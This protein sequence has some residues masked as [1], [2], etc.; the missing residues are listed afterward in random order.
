MNILKGIVTELRE[1]RLWPV[2]VALLIGLVAVPVVLSKS[3]S[4]SA[5]TQAPAAGGSGSTGHTVSVKLAGGPGDAGLHG[6]A[7]DPFAQQHGA[8]ATTPVGGV[9]A[10]SG[11]S[12]SLAS[13]GTSVSVGA[14]S[15][16]STGSGSSPRGGSSV[17][18][19]NAGGGS[20]SSVTSAGG[21]YSAPAASGQ[22]ATPVHTTKPAPAG[23][24][25]TQSY[26]VAIQVS[27]SSGG[28]NLLD[29]VERL[30]PIPSGSQPLLVELGVAQGGRRVLFAVQPGTIVTGPGSCTPGPIDCEILSLSPDQT[31]T[32]STQL[33]GGTT[34]AQFA[35]T[36]ISAADHPSVAAANKARNAVSAAGARLLDNSPLQALSLFDYEPSVGAVVDLRNLTVGGN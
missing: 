24:G 35:V 13:T 23:L 15:S 16:P 12:V 26:A 3:P 7:R 4:S 30:S 10:G 1:R 25:A 19:S 21:S 28:L 27:N 17:G 18:G 32:V 20:G 34:I 29:P 11:S 22:P 5:S 33:A 36:G 31:E 14:G 9:P 2:A 8:T 6:K